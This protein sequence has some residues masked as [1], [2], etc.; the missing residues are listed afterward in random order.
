M[1]KFDQGNKSVT[2]GDLLTFEKH[3]N[4]Q[5]GAENI[6]M[7]FRVEQQLHCMVIPPAVYSQ[8]LQYMEEL[9]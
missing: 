6:F 2:L 1:L 8:F 5:T 3:K 7:T 9:K 4:T